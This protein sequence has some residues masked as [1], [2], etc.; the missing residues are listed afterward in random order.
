MPTKEK[1]KFVVQVQHE[2]EPSAV[3][4]LLVSAF[5]G[6]SNYWAH[7]KTYNAKTAD[8]I[9]AGELTIEVVEDCGEGDEPVTHKLDLAALHRGLEI[10][11]RSTPGRHFN[12]FVNGDDDAETGDVFLQLCLLGK[13]VYG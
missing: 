12:N 9:V 13:I 5:E 3:A 2:F 11:A 10:M 7:P 8:R 1:G 6:G 4:N